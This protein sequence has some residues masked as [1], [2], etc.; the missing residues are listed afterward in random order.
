MS[1]TKFSLLLSFDLAD[2]MELENLLSK[3]APLEAYIEWLD[4][5][6]DRCLLKVTKVLLDCFMYIAI[7]PTATSLLGGISAY[8]REVV[9]SL[10]AQTSHNESLLLCLK[11]HRLFNLTLCPEPTKMGFCLCVSTSRRSL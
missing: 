5:V 6:V 8:N 2:V 4:S 9:F 10:V 7:G 1:D 11:W 3:Q